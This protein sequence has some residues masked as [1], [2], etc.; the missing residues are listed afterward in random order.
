MKN[1][2]RHGDCPKCGKSWKGDPIPK[3]HHKHYSPP[4][5]WSHLTG[6]EVRGKYDGVSYWQCPFCKTTWDRFTGD[7]VKK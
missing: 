7:E 3:E 2:D 4:Y 5:F 1:I 6:I